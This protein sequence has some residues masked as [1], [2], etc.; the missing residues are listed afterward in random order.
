[1]GKMTY[2]LGLV[3]SGL[4]FERKD[5]KKVAWREVQQLESKSQFYIWRH[6]NPTGGQWGIPYVA[7]FQGTI[8]K[9]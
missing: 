6:H 4:N 5:V 8:L 3:E 2:Y 9:I 7:K 1:M